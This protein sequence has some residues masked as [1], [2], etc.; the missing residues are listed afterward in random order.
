MLAA[1]V[2]ATWYTNSSVNVMIMAS[3]NAF[4]CRL[5]YLCC[6]SLQLAGLCTWWVAAFSTRNPG[7]HEH[8]YPIDFQEL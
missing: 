6:A 7:D 8:A 2:P 4:I 3:C 5:L 1:V